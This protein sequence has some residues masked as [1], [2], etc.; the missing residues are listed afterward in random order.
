MKYD[1]NNDLESLTSASNNKDPFWGK[2]T[3]SG[4]D[5]ELQASLSIKS[6]RKA[7]LFGTLLASA[8][9]GY[10]F[11]KKGLPRYPPP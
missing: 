6:P 9:C 2:C 11:L 4:R 7:K 5:F 10:F 1:A 8:I 3:F